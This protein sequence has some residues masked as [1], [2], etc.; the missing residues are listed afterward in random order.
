MGSSSDE[1]LRS[2][3]SFSARLQDGRVNVDS[4]YEVYI[5]FILVHLNFK[6]F[7]K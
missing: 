5:K 3:R 4:L 7:S 6:L 2:K 1:D